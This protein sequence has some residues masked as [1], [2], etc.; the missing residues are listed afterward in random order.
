MRALVAAALLAGCASGRVNN[1]ESVDAND[2]PPVGDDAKVWL[3]GSVEPQPDAPVI[4]QDA[5]VTP[6]A[7]QALPP[8]A[9][10]PV[11]A[12]RQL[13]A[14]PVLDLS[15]RGTSWSTDPID[16]SYPL[17]TSDGSPSGDTMPYK[18]WLGG[19]SGDDIGAWSATDEMHQDVAIPAG[20]T[21]LHLTGKYAVGTE[22]TTSSTVYD[23][24]Q[25]AITQ[26][27]GTPI[28]TLLS[29]SNLSK[30]GGWVAFDQSVS[31]NLS[32][33]TVRVRV[34]STNDDW[35]A[36]SFFFDSFALTATVCE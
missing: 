26:T 23:T 14:N 17:V 27:N 36:S 5:A 24:A 7:P 29:L 13:L 18:A 3:D 8:D 11:C 30:T 4:V 32:G 9:H 12:D 21:A 1:G 15:P 33:Q 35:N 28:Q 19:F 16:S 2:N 25:L 10:V 6:D 20:T 31:S 34:T 22:E